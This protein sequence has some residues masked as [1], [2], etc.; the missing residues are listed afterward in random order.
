[1]SSLDLVMNVIGVDR[2]SPAFRSAASASDHLDGSSRRARDGLTGLAS[3]SSALRGALAGGLIGAAAIGLGRLG[4]A[5]AESASDLN[6]TKSAIDQVFGKAASADLQAWARTASTAMGQSQQSALDAAKTFGVFGTAA[7]LSGEGLVDFSTD[8]TGLASD[9]ASFNNTSPEAAVEA[10][11]AALRGESEPIRAYGVM[12]DEATLKQRAM[13]MGIASGTEPLTQQQRVMAAYQEILAQTTL[14]QGDFARTGEGYANSMRT[15]KAAGAD[16]KA[17]IGEGLLP[18]VSAFATEVRES[19]PEVQAAVGEVMPGITAAMVDF[20][21]S[22]DGADLADKLVGISDA[23]ERNWPQIRETA[24][25]AADA[26]ERVSSITGVVW[27]A[28][29]AMPPEVRGVLASLAVLQKT[30]LISIAF[31]AANLAK[32]IFGAVGV[33]NVGVLNAGTDGPGAPDGPGKVGKVAKATGWGAAALGAGAAAYGYVR[34]TQ[35][36]EAADA[37]EA[38][39]NTFSSPSLIEWIRSMGQARDATAQANEVMRAAAGLTEGLGQAYTAAGYSTWQYAAATADAGAKSGATQQQVDAMS[40]A[41]AAIPPGAT[42]QEVAMRIALAGQAAGLSKTQTDAF[43]GA[44]LGVPAAGNMPVLTSNIATAGQALGLTTV[45]T[46]AMTQA[47]MAIPPNASLPQ[48]QAAIAEAGR[49]AGL[50]DEQIAG[51]T[52][53]VLSIPRTRDVTIT[54]NAGQARAELGDLQAQINALSGRDVYVGLKIIPGVGATVSDA[55]VSYATSHAAGGMVPVRVSNGEFAFGPSTAARIGYRTLAAIN[56]GLITG[57]GTGTSDSIAGFA[58]PGTYIMR[59]SAVRAAGVDSM[60][61]LAGYASGGVVSPVGV[62]PV[63]PEISLRAELHVDGRV[64]AD[65]LLRYR[66]AQGGAP[67][68]LG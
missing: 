11:G 5:A 18:V 27:D 64:L 45:Q 24:S 38:G 6:E 28:F 33:M 68:G 25:T 55:A 46:A 42:A 34:S 37:A 35:Q 29:M 1:M 57:P 7:G 30:G 51:V 39:T 15:I 2:A 53:S 60:M 50:T 14:Q 12:L 54:T 19:M 20:A 3:A 23:V 63:T 62:S 22:I 9:L 49:A 67:L 65:A 56:E 16:L 41:I 4:L 48:L 58:R 32:D 10:L 13:A 21:E 40:G 8:L 43:T 26:L 52:V 31:K 47:V 61:R 66:R 59:A 36:Q 17:Q 44:V